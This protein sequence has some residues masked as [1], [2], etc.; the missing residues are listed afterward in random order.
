MEVAAVI[1]V[2]L[3]AVF[4]VFQ[5]ALA[6][7]AALGAAAWGGRHR[8]VLPPA[9]RIASGVAAAVIYPAMALLVLASSGLV[10][11]RWWPLAGA[12]AMWL[13]T[14]F[15]AL[16]TLANLVSRSRIERIWAPVCLVIAVCCA[17]SAVAQ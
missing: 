17:V 2:L 1:A 3:L 6:A 5:L 13:L 14:A 9:L 10:A 11:A 4:A 16:G 7:G 8:G 15:F 12:T